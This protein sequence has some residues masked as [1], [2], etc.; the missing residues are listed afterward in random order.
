[1]VDALAKRLPVAQSAQ[2]AL[3][4]VE[5][6]ADRFLKERAVPIA[7]DRR[8]GVDRYSTPELL[9]LERQLV[10][11]AT[12]RAGESWAVVRPDILRQVLDRHSTLADPPSD[13]PLVA[14]LRRC[15]PS[16]PSPSKQAL[17]RIGLLHRS[18][19]R[20]RDIKV[21]AVVYPPDNSRGAI[22]RPLHQA[23]RC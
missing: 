18:H 17:K 6:A 15:R 2:E 4:Q 7:R 13:G 16:A 5:A 12:A 22:P 14:H 9:A 21:A 23:R 1:V 3:T 11:G 10:A 8:L 20:G 19:H